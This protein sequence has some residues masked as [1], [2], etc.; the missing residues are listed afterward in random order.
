MGGM[1]MPGGG[2]MWSFLG[3]WV[4]MMVAMMPMLWRYR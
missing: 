4:V 3:T 2:T 1:P